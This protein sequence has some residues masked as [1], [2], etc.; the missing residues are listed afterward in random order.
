MSKEKKQKIKNEVED[1][2]SKLQSDLTQEHETLET[3]FEKELM[4]LTASLSEQEFLLG[5]DF[6][7]MP[8]EY[9]RFRF[10]FLMPAM[11]INLINEFDQNLFIA[12]IEGC[13]LVNKLG[14]GIT[15]VK[16]DLN[17]IT[18]ADTWCQSK[19]FPNVIETKE[20]IEKNAEAP[21]EA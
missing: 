17:A 3:E 19:V 21:I 1:L 9:I 8:A 5:E 11:R 6:E 14:N 18:L 15:K 7:K 13:K 12:G 10:G 4:E 20:L 16:F 2:R